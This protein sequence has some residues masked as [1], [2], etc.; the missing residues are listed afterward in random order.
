[1][2]QPNIVLFLAEDLDYD[3]LNCYNAAA[4]GYTGLVRAGNPYAVE[5][6]APVTGMLTPTID[7]MAREGAM[8]EQYY[9]ASPLCTP[10]RYSVLTGR[11][12]ERSPE[13]VQESGGKPATICLIRQSCR[14]KSPFP[15]N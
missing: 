7:K 14:K 9:C 3:G 11:F 12:P 13:L 6:E 1:M 4:T 10:A 8:F 5:N 15:E 2:K